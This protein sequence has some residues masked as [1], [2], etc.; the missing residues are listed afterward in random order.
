MGRWSVIVWDGASWFRGPVVYDDRQEAESCAKRIKLAPAR[1]V[2][3][4]EPARGV[5]PPPPSPECRQK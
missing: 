4:D 2:P 3:D 5:W 1:V